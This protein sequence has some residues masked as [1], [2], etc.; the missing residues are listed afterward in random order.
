MKKRFQKPLNV[1][2]KYEHTLLLG[3]NVSGVGVGTKLVNGVD[4][5]EPSIRVYVKE[6]KATESLTEDEI[7]KE[8]DGVKTDV[9]Q[10]SLETLSGN[11][12]NTTKVRPLSGGCSLGSSLH[13]S[14]GTLGAIVRD[15]RNTQN[16]FALTCYHVIC[17]TNRPIPNEQIVQPSIGDTGTALDSIGIIK[18]TVLKE[19][20]DCGLVLLNQPTDGEVGKIYG[21]SFITG[22][23]RQADGIVRKF[24]KATGETTGKIEDYSLT[25]EIQYRFGITIRHQDLLLI[26]STTPHPFVV[27][28]DSGSLVVNEQFEAVGMIVG[29]DI[30]RRFGAAMKIRPILAHLEVSLI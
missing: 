30:T 12:S 17:P 14:G 13:N 19:G 21:Q 22:I 6:K 18:G 23:A 8:I 29:G 4:T 27:G 1:K 9:I 25:F 26:R 15:T 10:L 16:V 20:M 5:K 11:I 3:D 28:G 7:P 2:R 24:G